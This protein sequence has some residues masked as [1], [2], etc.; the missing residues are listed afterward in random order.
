MEI[1]GILFDKDGT[2]FDFERTWGIWFDRVI[3][4]LSNNNAVL[5]QSLANACGY[6]LHNERF[7]AGSIIVIA[8]AQAVNAALKECLP[9]IRLAQVDAV[10]RRHLAALPYVPV[11]DLGPFLQDLRDQGI[12]IGLATNDYFEGAQKQL[13]DAGIEELFDF[14]CGCDSGYGGKP[15]AGMVKAFCERTGLEPGAIAVVGDSVHDLESGQLAGVGLRVGVLT[16]PAKHDDLAPYADVVLDDISSILGAVE[17]Q[18]S[19]LV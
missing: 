2:L 19:H 5:K 12:A 15:G 7:V 14:I 18:D 1:K 11:C 13:N 3:S 17:I 10:A 16:G 9:D 8:T 6:D 4:E